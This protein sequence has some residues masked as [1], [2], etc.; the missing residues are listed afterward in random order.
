M[1]FETFYKLFYLHRFKKASGFLKLYL[2]ITLPLR[3]FLNTFFLPKK[4]DLDLYEQKSPNLYNQDL[5]FLF[6]HFNSDKGEFFVDQYMQPIK[7]II[8]KYKHMVIQ[9]FM[10]N[11]F[12]IKKTN[13]LI[14]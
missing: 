11:F 5:N 4:I 2:Y 9:N 8:K 7:K 10:K 14:F 1:K 3:F 6:E 12:F 13:S